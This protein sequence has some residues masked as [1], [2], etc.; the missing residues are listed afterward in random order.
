MHSVG[1]SGERGFP[2]VWEQS[3]TTHVEGNL[4]KTASYECIEFEP[5]NAT[6]ENLS[7]SHSSTK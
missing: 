3:L 7:S 2:T 1:E 6:S 4:G 5:S